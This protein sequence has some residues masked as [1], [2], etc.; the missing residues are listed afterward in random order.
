MASGTTT[1]GSGSAVHSITHTLGSS[2]YVT[3]LAPNWNT[4]CWVGSRTTTAVTV[5][6][7]TQVGSGGGQLNWRVEPS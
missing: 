1:I 2:G 6:F 3:A 7:G 4:T 5:Y